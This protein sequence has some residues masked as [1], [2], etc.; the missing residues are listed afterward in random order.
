MQANHDI[1]GTQ[2][3]TGTLRAGNYTISYNGSG[4]ATLLQGFNSL[5][6]VSASASGSKTATTVAGANFGIANL[7]SA[8][9]IAS[10]IGVNIQAP[11][12]SGGGTLTSAAGLVIASHTAGT[13]NT[14]ALI[15]TTTIPSGA[16]G[17]YNVA[18]SANYIN[19]T[20]LVGTTTTPTSA[21]FNLV[22]GG[23]SS[24][25]VLGAATADMISMAAVDYAAG[26]RR[27][28]IQGETGNSISFGN[29]RIASSGSIGFQPVNLANGQSINVESLTELTTIAAAATT[30]T[31]IQMPANAVILGVA[32]RTTVTI[33]TA[34]SYSVG[35]S[36]SATR[37]NTANVGV[38]A[39][40]TDRGTK[41]GAYYNAGALSVRLTMNGGTPADNSGRVRVTILYYTVT[42]PTS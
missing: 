33:P 15:G 5:A 13:N 18:T 9:T 30:D 4:N 27:L 24:T 20:I 38:A 19:G 12:N 21:T 34:T 14:H 25:P 41:A 32:V 11:V 37:F 28:Y 39:G 7:A 36:G 16:W 26:D 1:G 40:S 29:G 10:G 35:D 6:Q 8:Y 23:G 22:L 17:I 2:N 31:A 42:A 3:V